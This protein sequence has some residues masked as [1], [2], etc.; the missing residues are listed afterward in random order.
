MVSICRLRIRGGNRLNG[1]GIKIEKNPQCLV[2]P[3]PPRRA[4]EL[5]DAHRRCVQELVY[6][7]AHRAGYL[8]QRTAVKSVG[9]LQPPGQPGQLGIDH[10]RGLGPQRHDGRRHLGGVR[11]GPVGAEFFRDDRPSYFRTATT[12]PVAA[13]VGSPRPLSVGAVSGLDVLA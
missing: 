5:F 4:G 8:L 7:S 2:V 6:H 13:T 12:L 3:V 9:T 1:P 11:S 10:F